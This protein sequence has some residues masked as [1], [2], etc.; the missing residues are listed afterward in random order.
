MLEKSRRFSYYLLGL[1]ALSAC[2][3]PLE[4]GVDVYEG[5]YFR[6]DG[7]GKFELSVDLSKVEKFIKMAS[8]FNRDPSECTRAA[9][10]QAFLHT[11][12]RLKR[13]PEITQVTTARNARALRFKLSFK[14]RSIKALNRAMRKIHAR[15]DRRGMVYFKMNN[16]AFMR[17][18]TRSIARLVAYRQTHD[19]SYVTGFDL[20][21]FFKNSTYQ[22]VYSFD[23]PIRQRSH[24]LSRITQDR[25]T[26]IL[27][28]HIF[29]EQEKGVSF[30][31]KIVF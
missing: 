24:K 25:R 12:N 28:Q 14:F 17:V 13:V 26:V 9:V 30:S 11:A 21:T 3:M 20:E 19:D 2:S 18:D 27:N 31:N 16:H 5:A 23:K 8:Y 29:D 7:S 10:H 15:V 6:N 1:L 4:A 22:F